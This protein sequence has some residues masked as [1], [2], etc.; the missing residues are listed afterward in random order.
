MVRFPSQG[1]EVGPGG[2]RGA[3]E[4]V[5]KRRRR[6]N[7]AKSITKGVEKVFGHKWWRRRRRERGIRRNFRK[8][9]LNS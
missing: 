9:K 8:E 6:T 1:R 7:T 5:T 2:R 3:D 4:D